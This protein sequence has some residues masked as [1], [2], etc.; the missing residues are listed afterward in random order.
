MRVDFECF[1]I[2]E[3]LF[4]MTQPF[5]ATYDP[6]EMP[7]LPHMDTIHMQRNP[8]VPEPKM[9]PERE[10]ILCEQAFGLRIRGKTYRQ[11]AAL[12][13]ISTSAAYSR[14]QAFMRAEE[15][16]RPHFASDTREECASLL[17]QT[18]GPVVAHAQHGDLAS[19]RA[20]VSYANTMNRLV[21]EP[22]PSKRKLDR[23]AERILKY[24]N[25]ED[26]DLSYTRREKMEEAEKAAAAQK[27]REAGVQAGE[28]PRAE[29]GAL[30]AGA[31]AGEP[32]ENIGRT[33]GKQSQQPV[34]EQAVAPEKKKSDRSTAKRPGSGGGSAGINVVLMMILLAVTAA[35]GM[36]E[37][38]GTQSHESASFLPC[39][40]VPC[41]T[42]SASDG[43]ESSSA[44]TFDNE[45][46]RIGT[47]KAHWY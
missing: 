22:K 46:A 7:D 20:I 27:G 43:Q 9:T 28:C 37:F 3:G 45:I 35:L 2:D 6:N 41:A 11:M 21:K 1:R 24:M 25:E 39:A 40:V 16:L 32:A 29:P 8:H 17:R 31:E 4:S 14:A 5:R 38:G 18:I 30:G 47:G 12:L 44:P 10:Y 13:G 42:G 19:F 34:V 26:I 15:R 36:A 23:R 33:T